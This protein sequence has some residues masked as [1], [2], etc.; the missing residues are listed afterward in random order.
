MDTLSGEATLLLPLV[1]L[2]VYHYK[3]EFAPLAE[4]SFFKNE[5]QLRKLMLSREADRKLQK[6]I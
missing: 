5:P 4:N 2:A 6:L 3:K 1:S